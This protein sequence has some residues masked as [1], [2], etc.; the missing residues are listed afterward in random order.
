MMDLYI[1][2]CLSDLSVTRIFDTCDYVGGGFY[3]F[4]LEKYPQPRRPKASIPFLPGAEAY[5]SKA[6]WLMNKGRF[7]DAAEA[8]KPLVA[9]HPEVIVY[10]GDL[11]YCYAQL[12]DWWRS[13][14]LLKPIVDGG[15]MDALSMPTFG[16]AASSVGK[17][18]EADR[19]LREGLR[20][21]PGQD[22]VIKVC[23]GGVCYIRA[24]EC[25]SRNDAAG[26][27]KLLDEAIDMLAFTTSASEGSIE[28]QRQRKIAYATAVKADI[29]ATRGERDKAIRLYQEAIRIGPGMPG[30]EKWRAVAERLAVPSVAR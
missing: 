20:R 7:G 22:H 15:V 12:G 3:V 4:G 19:V 2:Y 23:L 8:Y 14:R 10:K 30:V 27:E 25:L 17:P 28:G 18:D 13:Y 11:G 24:L 16:A 6:A 21:Y 29:C 5:Y 1:K 9:R 26:A